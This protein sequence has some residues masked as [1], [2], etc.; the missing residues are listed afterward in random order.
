[1]KEAP[2]IDWN[3]VFYLFLLFRC[4]TAFHSFRHKRLW[5]G[6]SICLV[7]KFA[8]NFN[9]SASEV[10]WQ[11]SGENLSDSSDFVDLCCLW[12]K[13]DGVNLAAD[14]QSVPREWLHNLSEDI[15]T[16]HLFSLTFYSHSCHEQLIP[17]TYTNQY[18]LL[19]YWNEWTKPDV[20]TDESHLL[21]LSWTVKN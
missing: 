21:L 9:K 13:A 10:A 7:Q 6:M 18:L 20:W 15:F 19:K 1:M 2:N 8:W 11:A 5:Q 12:V 14:V 17:M 4:V 3:G 16:Q